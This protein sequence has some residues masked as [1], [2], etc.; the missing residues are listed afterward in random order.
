MYVCLS[1]KNFPLIHLEQKRNIFLDLTSCSQK[2]SSGQVSVPVHAALS[3]PA[4]CLEPAGD[5]ERLEK[6]CNKGP[7]A[8]KASNSHSDKSGPSEYTGFILV[9]FVIV[10]LWLVTV[11]N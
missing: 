7:A 4:V 3:P 9:I 11:E 6:R 8:C 5:P 10:L 1:L 2:M